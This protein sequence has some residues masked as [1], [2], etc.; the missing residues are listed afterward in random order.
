MPQQ[1]AS[2]RGG[3]EGGRPLPEGA[4]VG[5]PL[6]CSAM[7]WR[8]LTKLVLAS[9]GNISTLPRGSPRAWAPPVLVT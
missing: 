9:E 1:I 5:Y 6:T 2:W 4:K 8:M 7:R 3:H